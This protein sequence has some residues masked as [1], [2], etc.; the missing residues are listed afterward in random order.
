L[1]SKDIPAA[2]R[3]TFPQMVRDIVDTRRDAIFSHDAALVY[4]FKA[5]LTTIP[6]IIIVPIQWRCG[7]SLV[8]RIRAAISRASPSTLG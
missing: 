2:D 7:L 8:S 1:S 6:I 4:Q 3:L 5:T